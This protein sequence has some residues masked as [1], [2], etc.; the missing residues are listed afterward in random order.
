MN[1]FTLKHCSNKSYKLVG[2]GYI[3][4]KAKSTRFGAAC[5]IRTGWLVLRQA[6]KINSLR[7][8]IKKEKNKLLETKFSVVPSRRF[9]EESARDTRRHKT[10]RGTYTH[11]K[12]ALEKREKKKQRWSCDLRSHCKAAFSARL[13]LLSGGHTTKTQLVKGKRLQYKNVYAIHMK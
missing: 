1:F 7:K 3:K 6:E 8:I 12:R 5:T 2:K 4:R 11:A 13:S 9:D 10:L